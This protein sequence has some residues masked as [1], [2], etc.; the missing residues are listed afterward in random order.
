MKIAVGLMAIDTCTHKPLIYL[1]DNN[2]EHTTIA[3]QN[4]TILHITPDKCSAFNNSTSV[5][6]F[7]AESSILSNIN[8]AWWSIIQKLRASIPVSWM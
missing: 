5:L 7:W 6:T 2:F 4:V 3:E 8:Q 1:W